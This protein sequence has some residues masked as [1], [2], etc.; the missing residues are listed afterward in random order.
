MSDLCFLGIKSGTMKFIFILFAGLFAH[1][2]AFAQ[3]NDPLTPRRIS[4]DTC[5]TDFITE[6]KRTMEM[7]PYNKYPWGMCFNEYHHFSNNER[8]WTKE[9]INKWNIGYDNYKIRRWGYG[10]YQNMYNIPNGKLFIE[11]CDSD[12]YNIIYLLKE[13]LRH[14]KAIAYY[15]A[16]DTI[17]DGEYFYGKIIMTDWKDWTKAHFI[18]VMIHEMGHALGLPHVMDHGKYERYKNLSELMIPAGFGCDLYL[19]NICNFTDYDFEAFILPFPLWPMTKEGYKH[20]KEQE[21]ERDRE[22]AR[23]QQENL[24]KNMCTSKGC[25]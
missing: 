11:S 3:T 5:G 19:Q 8:E 6:N 12:K 13:D 22:R 17:W 20:Y 24:W 18:N 21:R 7:L 23:I 4:Y 10:G 25:I 15:S 14:R 16:I 9:A 1:S 2:Q